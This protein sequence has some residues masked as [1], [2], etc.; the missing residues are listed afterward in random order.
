MPDNGKNPEIGRI[1]KQHR[2]VMSLTMSDLAKKSGVSASHLGR[3][4]SGEQF[5][6]ARILRKI[7]SPLGLGEISCLSLLATYPLNLP[8]R[9]RTRY[10][11]QV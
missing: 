3:I 11:W 6:S 7:A 9:L 5:P 8:L 1:I 2:I 4:E 10:L